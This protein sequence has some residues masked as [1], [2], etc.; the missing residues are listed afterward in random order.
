MLQNRA[1][2][3]TLIPK[4]VITL[5]LSDETKDDEKLEY[6]QQSTKLSVMIETIKLHL[7]FRHLQFFAEVSAKILANLPRL[8]QRSSAASSPTG[9]VLSSSSISDAPLIMPEMMRA[10]HKDTLAQGR[11]GT[12]ELVIFDDSMPAIG[13]AVQYPCLRLVLN[14]ASGEFGIIVEEERHKQRVDAGV[15]EVRVEVARQAGD[16]GKEEDFC[17]KD[18]LSEEVQAYMVVL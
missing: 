16:F 6:Q 4:T 11:L 13:K 12:L 2:T 15:E 9:S 17:G 18:F 14:K 5:D 10:L 1:V 8:E 7:A 3:A